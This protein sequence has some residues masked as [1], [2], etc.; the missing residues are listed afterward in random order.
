MS[1]VKLTNEILDNTLQQVAQVRCLL[2]Q[3]FNKKLT[4]SVQTYGCQ[5]NV[6]D[7]QFVKGLL[8]KMGYTIVEQPQDADLVVFNTCAVREHAEM[9]VFGNIGAL[10]KSKKENPDMLI[11]I[12]GCMSQQEV[13]AKKI[14]QSYPYVDIVLGTGAAHLL[15]QAIYSK[16]TKK[17]RV[18]G[19]ALCQDIVEGLPVDREN[20]LRGWLPIMY[21]C[22]N[23]C[24]Y[25]IVPYVRGR[26]RSRKPE[27]IIAEAKELIASGVKEI[28]LLGQNVNSYG[29]TE[30]FKTDFSDILRMIND[31]EGDFRISFMTSHPKDC[32]EKLIRTIAECKKVSRRIHLP[33]QSGSDRILKLMNRRYTA[34]KYL[35]LINLAKKT[36]PDVTFTSDIIVGFPGETEQDFE[37]TLNLVR[38]VEFL[39]L[40]TFIYSKRQGTPAATMDDPTTDAQKK[41]RFSRLLKLQD[42]MAQRVNSKMVGKTVTVLCDGK[43]RLEGKLAGRAIN[44]AVVEFDGDD[45]LIGQF[46]NVKIEKLSNVLEGI[47]I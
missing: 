43:G 37:D 32:T 38:Q 26:E 7:S 41:E 33:F 23:F 17:K 6:N 1:D 20:S 39:S 3:K 30:D 29:N 14:K 8:S 34:K 31:L 36:I 15:P 47:I 46:V 44:D 40:F 9:R 10:K 2:E 27:D 42:D 22:N 21:G 12:M 5:Q 11:A 28:T 25:C 4:A 35:D 18:F 16:L 45:N 24:S 13:I 19:D